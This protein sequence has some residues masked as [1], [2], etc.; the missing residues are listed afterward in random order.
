M[1]NEEL[2][3]CW[4]TYW[5]LMI[6]AWASSSSC[7]DHSCH[8]SNDKSLIH[9]CIVHAPTNLLFMMPLQI[10]MAILQWFD[11]AFVGL[12]LSFDVHWFMFLLSCFLFDSIHNKFVLL[13]SLSIYVFTFADRGKTSNVDYIQSVRLARVTY[14]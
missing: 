5:P 3:S 4:A 1:V 11:M 6:N 13:Y 14:F 7:M 8:L 12:T 2:F 10:Y 9:A